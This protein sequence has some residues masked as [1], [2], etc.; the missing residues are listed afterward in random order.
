M[1]RVDYAIEVVAWDRTGFVA[2][3][4]M[5]CLLFTTE[6]ALRIQQQNW[7]FFQDFLNLLDYSLVVISWLD[8]A[9]S[10]TTYRER[11]QF[12]STVRVFRFVRFVRLAEGHYTGLFKIAKGLA[13]ALEPV[14]QLTI[15]TSAFVFTCAVFL[16]GLVAHD[17]VAITRWPEARMYAGSVWRSTLTV[18]QVMTFDLWSDITFGIMQAGSPLTLIVIFGSIFG[19]SFGIIN[20]MVGI[21]VERVS[22]ISADAA[23][24]Q[25][26]A[27]AKAYEML[28]QSILAD[29]RYHMN[30]DGKI[31]FEA[32]RRLLNVSEVK[33]KLSLMGLS[34]EEAEAFFYLMDGEKVG[35][36]TPYQLVTALGK[37]KGKAKSHDMC[38]LI[39]I[40]QKQC[41]RA[42]RLVDRVHRL[43][44][45]VDRIQ[46]RFCDCGRGLTR[47]R[48][49]T[50]EADARTQEMHS[51]A[52]DRERIFQKVELQRQV[53]QARM[54]MA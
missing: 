6:L 21:M 51:R 45:Q 8:V 41:L 26:K 17:W 23:D 39:C 7:G 47:E 29:F 4:G 54:K 32:Y 33:E 53:A 27:A 10:V 2:L 5:F 20:A 40:V 49:I 9:T 34:P 28:L 19:C 30:R 38:Y 50:R 12:A 46:S 52:E 16:T 42:S 35:E 13:D 15:I 18:M 44:E 37:A 31:D 43:I 25:E 1:A 22:N 11:V 3:E 24:N 48:L 36:V 14:V